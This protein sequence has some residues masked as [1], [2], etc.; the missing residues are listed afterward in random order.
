[1]N[2]YGYIESGGS[3]GAS[4]S[5]EDYGLIDKDGNWQPIVSIEHEQDINQLYVS[6][7]LG[8]IPE[9][10][11]KKGIS[12]GI[13]VD[14]I[15]IYDIENKS[16]SDEVGGRFYTFYV[17]NYWDQIK[18]ANLYTNS[19]Y[20]DIFDEAKIPFITP[21]ELSI[22]ISEKEEQV[23]ATAEIKKGKE[24]T[25]K[26]L[27]G[28]MFSDYLKSKIKLD[29]L[30]KNGLRVFEDQSFDVKLDS[31]G[32]V[33]FVS[34]LGEFNQLWLYLVNSN[35]EII[36]VFPY[37]YTNVLSDLQEVNAVSFKDVNKDGL[38]DITIIAHCLSANGDEL[39]M[40]NVYF[41]KDNGFMNSYQLDEKIN[42]TNN[43]NSINEI[44]KYVNGLNLSTYGIK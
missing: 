16:N 42:D 30:V 4:N 12:D 29:T 31:F 23:G 26:T 17:N 43:N 39:T 36:Y 32:D 21:D 10:A 35:K 40:A 34:G 15:Y 27:S 28:N 1:L 18:D 7:D 20:K 5:G 19:K 25:W 13:E 41:Q 14:T 33:R 11:E 3:S 2:E 8:Q 9:V 6:D 38:K 44:T 24:V 37:F 22:M